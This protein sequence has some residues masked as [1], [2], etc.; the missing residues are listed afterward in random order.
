MISD[1]KRKMST[2]HRPVIMLPTST[3]TVHHMIVFISLFLLL[4][5]AGAQ[6]GTNDGAPQDNT[7]QNFSPS[8]S[9]IIVIL[10]GALFFM[11]FFSVYIRHCAEPSPSGSVG[12]GL[13][14]SLRR[15]TATRGLDPAV[16]DTFPTFMYSVVKGLKIGKGALECAVC[17]NEFEDEENLR[18]IPKCDHVFHPECID[19]WLN[20]HVTC[21]VCR[22]DLVPQPGET[23]QI[24]DFNL[25]IDDSEETQNPQPSRPEPSSEIWVGPVQTIR[26]VPQSHS[27]GTLV[28][29][30]ENTDRF[31]LRL[32]EDVRK[33][34]IAALNRTTSLLVLPGEGSSRRGYRAG[35]GEGS[36]RGIGDGSSRGRRSY[37]RLDRTIMSDRWVF[38]MAPPFFTRHVLIEVS[39]GQGGGDGEGSTSSTA[40][41]PR[42]RAAMK[43]PSFKCMEPK[44]GDET[45]LV[46]TGS[47]RPQI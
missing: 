32:P 4:S 34:V 28:Q 12:A 39:E 31:T 38:S 1:E 46:S 11:G 7:L 26:E 17:L 40:T 30:G 16:I 13:R 41:T 8:M 9:I 15:R 36:S 22:T 19:A 24:P 35:I 47:D 5:P 10:V 3:Y 43:L 2:S 18:L 14:R 45:G 25:Q 27:P 42:G 29:P 23:L 44:A 21:P 33:K 6:S 37:R 20:A